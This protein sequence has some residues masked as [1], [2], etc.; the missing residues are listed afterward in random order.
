[1]PG[2]W[3]SV[4]LSSM[5]RC[6]TTV[7]GA[8]LVWPWSS[9]MRRLLFGSGRK[10]DRGGHQAANEASRVVVTLAMF[11]HFGHQRAFGPVG[12]EVEAPVA[13]GFVEGGLE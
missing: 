8:G 9:M 11:S 10:V 3:V 6:S 5:H 1:M 7:P 12:D 4:W 13:D 2:Y